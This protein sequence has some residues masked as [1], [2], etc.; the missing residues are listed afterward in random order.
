MIFNMSLPNIDDEIQLAD[1]GRAIGNAVSGSQSYRNYYVT[2]SAPGI[3][4]ISLALVR[5]SI[6]KGSGSR[7]YQNYHCYTRKV[8]IT[9]PETRIFTYSAPAASSSSSVSYSYYVH[10]HV[11]GPEQVTISSTGPS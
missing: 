4:Y 7:T 8:T 6:P 10:V 1:T 2:F 3:Y 11:L 5:M 9:E